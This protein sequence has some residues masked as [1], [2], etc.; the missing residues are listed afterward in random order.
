MNI[1]ANAAVAYLLVALG[2]LIGFMVCAVL[3]VSSQHSRAEEAEELRRQF[4]G[5]GDGE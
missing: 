2:F 4:A 3:T 5:F 1:V